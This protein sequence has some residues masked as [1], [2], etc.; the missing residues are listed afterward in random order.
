MAGIALSLAAKELDLR[1]ARLA[2]N[3]YKFLGVVAPYNSVV[4][5]IIKQKD[6]RYA[7]QVFTY[8]EEFV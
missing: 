2:S 1:D 8:K 6:A 5:I 4:N 7:S 3:L